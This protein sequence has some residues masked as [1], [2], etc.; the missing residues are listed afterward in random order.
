MTRYGILLLLAVPA[1]C[2]ADKVEP[3][4]GPYRA[5]VEVFAELELGADADLYRFDPPVDV[6]GEN[7]FRASLE[8]LA[9]F[10]AQVADAALD[11]SIRFARARA[12]ERLQDFSG[13]VAAYRAVGDGGGDLAPMALERLPFAQRM[14]EL[15]LPLP[16]ELTPAEMFG[17]LERRRADLRQFAE[18]LAGDPRASLV[19]V[20]IERLDVRE[21]EFRWRLRAV[22]PRGTE[23]ALE[24]ARR[25]VAEHVDSRRV[26][27]H[28]LRLADQYAELARA[29]LAA[30]DPAGHDFDA[31]RAENLLQQ[32]ANVYAEVAAVD[33]R[34]ERE[35]ARAELAALELL[36]DRIGGGAR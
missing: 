12:A 35:E 33:G 31:S 24:C 21:R 23:S 1:G 17:E 16:D 22:L 30:V 13:A 6:T 14:A 15:T 5:V 36:R 7:L 29:S 28:S 9:R 19:L 3:S 27:E 20:A 11:E 18:S 8:R 10:E 4:L 32:A 26:L 34:R 2:A 25:V